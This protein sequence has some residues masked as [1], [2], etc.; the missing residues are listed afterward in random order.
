MS[1]QEGESLKT[2]TVDVPDTEGENPWTGTNAPPSGPAPVHAVDAPPVPDDEAAEIASP[3]PTHPVDQSLLNEFD[4]LAEKATHEWEQEEGHLPAQADASGTRS[5]I[6]STLEPDNSED[7]IPSRS[8]VDTPLPVVV[9]DFPTTASSPPGVPSPTTLASLA[10][11][12]RRASQHDFDPPEASSSSQFNGNNQETAGPRIPPPFDFQKFLDQMKSKSAEPVVKYFRSFL[13]NFQKRTFTVTDQVK[14]IHDF[15]AFIAERMRECDVWKNLPPDDFDNATE[16]ME[17]LVMN[18]LYHLTFTPAIDRT[19][20]PIT[21]DD[22]ERDH[23]L[24]QRIKLFE[25]VTEDHLD[26]PTGE[27]S[28]GFIMF[29]EQELLKINHYKAPRDKLICILNCCKVIFGLIRH[30]N[31]EEGADAF[32]PILIYVVLQA[33][34]DHLLSNVEYISRFRSAA[35]LQ[36]EAGYYLSSLMGAVSFIETMDHTSLSNISQE[37]F[38]RNV[39]EAVAR[40]SPSSSPGPTT[41]RRARPPVPEMT[42]EQVTSPTA[43]EESARQLIL[44]NTFAEDTKRFFQRTGDLAQQTISKPLNAIGRIFTEAL[45]EPPGVVGRAIDAASSWVQPATPTPPPKDQDVGPPPPTPYKPRIRQSPSRPGSA[46]STPMGTPSRGGGTLQPFS[47]SPFGTSPAN[48]PRQS[49]PDPEADD[50]FDFAA[51]SAEIDRAHDAAQQAGRDTLLQIFPG[52]D[53]E[54]ADMVLEANN[55]DLGRSIDKL[56]EMGIGS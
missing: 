23:V 14:L 30:L 15:L 24:S 5:G 18:R 45:E 50:A 46:A 1:T 49:T 34:P 21:T 22:L 4:P 52:L 48:T 9:P 25:W 37:D 2:H 33:N 40:L 47:A 28:K 10:Q 39:E 31:R 41:P 38:E 11:P 56:L 32:I 54:V 19:I 27:G 29:A 35:K 43:G 17:K 44:P 36:S 6:A 12:L 8:E 53:G 42:T 3:V 20:Y 26:I 13:H 16:A 55:G 51:I 7:P